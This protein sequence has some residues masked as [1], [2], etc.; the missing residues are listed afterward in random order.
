MINVYGVYDISNVHLYLLNIK[1]SFKYYE[2]S[3]TDND[4][5]IQ[6]GYI[7]CSTQVFMT[8]IH[9]SWIL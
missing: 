9:K 3:T 5:G 4:K 6:F 7:L 8:K 1:T 2:I